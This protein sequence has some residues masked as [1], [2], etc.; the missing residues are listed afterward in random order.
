MKHII[1]IFLLSLSINVFTQNAENKRLSVF[2]EG[3]GI[4]SNFIRNNI[5][6]VDFVN[7]S[8]TADVHVIFS[9]K[10][11]GG[12]GTEYTLSFYGN[13]FEKIGNLTLSCFT[14]SFD[15]EVKT[16]EKLIS[17]LKA[18]LLPYL[19]EKSGLSNIDILQKET[20]SDIE[21]N[22]DDPKPTIDNW[23]NWVF[24]IGLEGGFSGEEQKKSFDYSLSLRA[25]KITDKWKIEN[26]YDYN[27]RE[28]KIT[29][30]KMVLKKL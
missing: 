22:E 8:K 26:E 23:K 29:N 14:Y 16:R 4:D 7:D 6:F 1:T 10:S 21:N 25:N 13:K 2:I 30:L 28:S 11:T 9:R 24:R 20:S 3:R 18:G 17:S 15:T 5:K 27:R 12:G 19:N